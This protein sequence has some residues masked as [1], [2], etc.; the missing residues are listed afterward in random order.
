MAILPVRKS[1][2]SLLRL[3]VVCA[4]VQWSYALSAQYC[5]TQNTGGGASP[6]SSIYQ[7]NGLCHDTCLASYAFAIVQGQNCWCSNYAPAAQ[8]STSKCNTPCPGFPDELCGNSDQS[9]YGYISLNVA[10]SGT[11]GVASSSTAASASRSSPPPTSTLWTTTLAK[12]SETT[13]LPQ[14]SATSPVTLPSSSQV[15]SATSAPAAIASSTHQAASASQSPTHVTQVQVVTQSGQIITQT[16]TTTPTVPASPNTS[17]KNGIAPGYVAAAVIAGLLGLVFI[18]AGIWLFMRRKENKDGEKGFQ[19]GSSRD[20]QRNISVH[21]KAGLL[22]NRNGVPAINT[23]NSGQPLMDDA[24]TTRLNPNA[25][26]ANDNGSKTSLNTIDDHRDYG[27]TLQ[28]T[29]PDPTR[30]SFS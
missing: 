12:T 8:G 2:A 17:R 29:N 11:L 7:S 28:V 3:L 27:R 20:M 30:T 19:G 25:L 15:P 23:R 26:M 24:A 13:P 14:E 18:V 4:Q 22:A 16:I 21:S 1:W 9:L 10:P 6:N 5:S